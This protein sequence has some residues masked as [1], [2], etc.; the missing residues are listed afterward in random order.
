[1]ESPKP[2]SHW[3]TQDIQAAVDSYLKMLILEQQGEEINK[4]FEN[5]I[6]RK[7][8]SEE[9]TESSIEF[10]M[11][12]ISAVLAELGETWIKGYRPAKNVGTNVK[13]KIRTALTSWLLPTNENHLPTYDDNILDQRSKKLEK[14]HIISIPEGI[15]TPEKTYT[16]IKKYLRSPEVRAWVRRQAR[17]MCEGCDQKAP[18][19]VEGQPFLEIHHVKHLAE[20]GSDTISNAVALCPNCHRRAHYS[21]DKQDFMS[22]LYSKITRLIKENQSNT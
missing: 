21:S 3:N 8:L 5:R 20:G 17:G 11:Q 16:S 12:N 22:L 9:R 7:K 13:N 19:D 6:L 18:F 14:Q 4:A 10:R 1:M 2:K 15:L